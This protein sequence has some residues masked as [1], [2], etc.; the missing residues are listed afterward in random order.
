MLE[1]NNDG[2]AQGSDQAGVQTPGGNGGGKQQKEK[3]TFKRFLF[4]AKHFEY[5]N[6]A[7]NFPVWLWLKVRNAVFFWFMRMRIRWW[8]LKSKWNKFYY[9]KKWL[10][11]MWLAGYKWIHP[12][13]FIKLYPP[14]KGH[15][16]C[17]GK[18]WYILQRPVDKRKMIVMCDCVQQKYKASGKK[19]LLKEMD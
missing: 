10:V 13:E 3:L 16:T 7:R 8:S 19:W 5:K 12:E 17:G 18:G 2:K 4:L 9:R 14:K 15:K 1:R 11:R 6:F